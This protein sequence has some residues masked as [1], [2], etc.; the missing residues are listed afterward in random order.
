MSYQTDVTVFSTL[1]LSDH[2][3]FRNVICSTFHV[4]L[5]GDGQQ[6]RSNNQTTHYRNLEWM[7]RW[8]DGVCPEVLW[9]TE[10]LRRTDCQCGKWQIMAQS[11]MNSH[12]RGSMKSLFGVFV[13]F[14]VKLYWFIA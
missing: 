7:E 2:A 12:R 1:T 4:G 8:M 13:Y 14:P 3:G 9:A 10:R 5:A 11:M 6:Q